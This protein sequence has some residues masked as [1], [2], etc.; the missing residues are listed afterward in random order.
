MEEQKEALHYS[1]GKPD[2]SQL[3][4]EILTEEAAIYSYGQRKYYRNNWALGKAWHEFSASLLRHFLE[5]QAGHDYD[6]C[7]GLEVDCAQIDRSEWPDRVRIREAINGEFGVSACKRHSGLHHLAHIRW[8][9]GTL[10]FY[11]IHGLGEDDRLKV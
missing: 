7:D 10:R 9:A 3:L 11:Q 2:V 4:P 8:N 5:F 1:S 6:D